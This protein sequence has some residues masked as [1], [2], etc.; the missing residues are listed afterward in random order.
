MSFLNVLKGNAKE[1]PKH[2]LKSPL[3][4]IENIRVYFY[5]K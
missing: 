3:S 1:T 2:S 4:L 5:P